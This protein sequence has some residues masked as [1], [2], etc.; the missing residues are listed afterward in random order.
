MHVKKLDI[1][2]CFAP[3]TKVMLLI[4]I[5]LLAPLMANASND[6]TIKITNS[7][8]TVSELFENIEQ[9]T[10]LRF[11][12][13]NKFDLQKRVN[14]AGSQQSLSK[15]M[16]A[17]LKDTQREYVISGNYI[18]IKAPQEQIATN[19]DTTPHVATPVAN[20][21][22]NKEGVVQ[23]NIT[24]DVEGV[25]YSAENSAPLSNIQ[26]YISGEAEQL[27]TTKTDGQ[28]KFNSLPYGNYTITI[29]NS[30][31]A[32]AHLKLNI[33]EQPIEKLVF[34]LQQKQP[35][36]QNSYAT[37]SFLSQKISYRALERS[38]KEPL[39]QRPPV[40]ALKTNILYDATASLNLAAE[41]RVGKK[42]TLELPVTYNPWTY[43]DNKKM[44]LFMVQ[45]EIRFWGHEPFNRHFFGVHFLYAVYNFGG[46]KPFGLWS[47]LKDSRYEGHIFGGGVSVGHQWILSKRLGLEATLGVGYFYTEYKKYNCQTCGEYVKKAPKHYFGPTKLGVSL[48]YFFK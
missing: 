23:N 14:L 16:T 37:N 6:P 26:I 1:L 44:K 40:V 24:V 33:S 10:S 13:D 4:T 21:D 19:S 12:F 20:S 18:V 28:F 27:T 39:K 48:V 3:M 46:L 22:I 35:T 30:N 17:V 32:T 25:V 7:N 41:I 42:T 36:S 45:P 43:S 5:W 38:S 47:N 29:S 9:Q 34:V 11:T 2:R 8:P 15:I 31:Y